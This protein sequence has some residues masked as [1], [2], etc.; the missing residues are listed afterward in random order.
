MCKIKFYINN[1]VVCGM[2]FVVL[3]FKKCFVWSD[4]VLNIIFIYV[5]SL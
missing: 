5:D 1:R 4:L 2:V 3:K